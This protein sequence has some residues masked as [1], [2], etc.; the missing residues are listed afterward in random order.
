MHR[1]LNRQIKKYLSSGELNS[2]SIQKFM[3]AVD[4]AYQ[5]MDSDHELL[6]HAMD[7]GSKELINKN[8]SLLNEVIEKEKALKERVRAERLLN[9]QKDALGS[10]AKG[11]ALKEILDVLAKGFEEIFIGSKCSILLL[12][13]E[14]Q[15]LFNCSS[16]SLPEKYLNYINGT[17]IGPC[18]GSCGTAVYKG[19]IVIVESIATDPLWAVARDVALSYGLLSCWSCPVWGSGNQI[20]GTFAVYYGTSK[21]PKPDELEVIKSMAYLVGVAIENIENERIVLEN[22][23]E[24]EDRVVKRTEELSQAKEEAEKA[25]QIKSEFLARMS[26]ELRTPMNAILGFAQLIQMDHK[27]PLA[28]YQK[29]N[30]ERV[31][32]AGHHLLMLINEI[33]DLS[34]IESGEIGLEV[35]TLDL[36]PIVNNVIS[37]SQSLA[38]ERNIS[39]EYEEILYENYF[40]EADPLRFK[41]IVLNLISNAIKYNK[42]NGSVI[43][44]LKHQGNGK[45]RLGIQDTGHGIAE[46]KIDKLFK[47]F[48]RFDVDAE[49]IEGAGIG[50]T[51]SKQLIEMMHGTIGFESKLGEGSLFYI[52]IPVSNKVPVPQKIGRSSDSSPVS[53]ILK[54]GKQVLYIE[55]IPANVELV[56]QIFSGKH[57]IEL[58]SA[59]NALDGIKIA[60][61]VIPDLILMDIH[62]PGMDGL[63]A[64]KKLQAIE[65][66]HNIPI[67]ALTADAMDLDI[68]KALDMGFH[69]YI[70]KP[71]DVLK[72]LE[73]VDKVLMPNIDSEFL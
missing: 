10:L 30:M 21:K 15:R 4:E 28:D 50:L 11:Q 43:V 32:S 5:Q 39:L 33:L 60:E 47:P 22:Q 37:I 36:I 67:I 59:P 20:M 3:N 9:I 62:L 42:I 61:A 58:L 63:E 44:S 69:S 72:F 8:Q 24:L 57:N 26:H 55:D 49:Q 41:Q 38:S 52:D 31:S 12:N 29:E 7:L 18:V 46:D 13:K 2:P 66:T 53:S 16:P 64:F 71:I 48:E 23:L 14:K 17:K 40:V 6:E 19:E 73:T 27:N 54:N 35:E 25:N 70:T 51:I 34:K 56:K 45:I 68:K 65:A 1:L